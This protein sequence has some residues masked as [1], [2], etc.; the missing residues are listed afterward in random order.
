[1]NT[2]ALLDHAELFFNR[3]KER[4]EGTGAEQYYDP[5]TD[6]Q[7]FETME[8]EEL[9]EYAREEAYD[10]A[11]YALMIALRVGGMQNQLDDAEVEEN[12]LDDAEI[13]EHPIMNLREAVEEVIESAMI[14]GWHSMEPET[15]LWGHHVHQH[16]HAAITAMR[17]ALLSEEAIAAGNHSLPDYS[18]DTDA[19]DVVRAMFSRLIGE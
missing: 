14:D 8:M 13:A 19:G 5:K 1:M 17:D 6:T 12:Q 10:L 15:S 7:K 3:C 11:N 2:K 16:T 4:L 9:F 18:Q